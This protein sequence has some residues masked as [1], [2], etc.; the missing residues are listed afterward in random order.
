MAEAQYELQDTNTPVVYTPP[1]V[2]H[3]TVGEAWTPES[4]AAK[5]TGK[6][7]DQKHP[8]ATTDYDG[9]VRLTRRTVAEFVRYYSRAAHGDYIIYRPIDPAEAAIV[10]DVAIKAC[11][12]PNIGYSQSYSSSDSATNRT[13]I[14]RYGVDTTV[15]INCDCSS[16]GSYCAYVATGINFGAKDSRSIGSAL[17]KTGHFM[18]GISMYNVSADNLPYNGD[19]IAKDGHVAMI[20]AGHPREGMPDETIV[21]TWTGGNLNMPS[22]VLY[23]DEDGTLSFNISQYVDQFGNQYRFASRK[24]A[25][26]ETSVFYSQNY[27]VNPNGSYAWGRFSEIM[28]SVCSLYQQEARK[29]YLYKEDGYRREIAPALGAVMC[30]TNAYDS[31]DPGWVCIVEKIDTNSG[32]IWVSQ[33]DP[34]TGAFSYVEKTKDNRNWNMDLNGDG[35]YEYVFQGFIH[36]P[37]VSLITESQSALDT[38]VEIAKEQI[39]TNGDFTEQY[40]GLKTANSA[41][42][43]AF[44]LAVAHKTGGLVNVIIP[45]TTSC[46]DIGRVGYLRGM[47]KWYDGPQS[48]KFP[49]PKPGDIAL[50]RNST[51]PDRMNRYA[52]DK[53]GIIVEVGGASGTAAG[54]NQGTNYSFTVVM[55]DMSGKVKSKKYSTSS[56]SFSGIYRPDW[57]SVDGTTESLNKF[58]TIE[59]LYTEGTALED[60]AVR[61]LRY[62]KLT[63]KGFEPSIKSSGMKLCAINYTGMLANLYTAFAEVASSAATDAN[64]VVDLWNNSV[65]SVYQDD[66]ISTISLVSDSVGNTIDPSIAIQGSESGVASMGSNELASQPGGSVAT[67]SDAQVMNLPQE[68]IANNSVVSI[69]GTGLS[70]TA[71]ASRI[72]QVNTVNVTFNQKIV[73]TTA[74]KNIYNWLNAELNNPAAC[75]GIM[76]NM[77]HISAFDPNSTDDRTKGAGLIHWANPSD[78]KLRQRCT[79]MKQF[80]AQRTTSGKWKNNPQGQI[81]FIF[82]EATTNSTLNIGWSSIKKVGRDIGGAFRA[83]R[84]FLDYFVLEAGPMKTANTNTKQ[85]KNPSTNYQPATRS[86][87]DLLTTEVATYEV[88]SGW[89]S[90][91]WNLFFGGQKVL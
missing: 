51:F 68:W 24:T 12:N 1:V 67:Q 75:I 63:K 2:T 41:W 82:K 31:T 5:N 21:G 89:A 43:A 6:K 45:N 15:P 59:G 50:F 28:Q 11:N 8:D 18:K 4:G 83:T 44:I 25:P 53:A 40:T 32:T 78:K 30:Y 3:I 46:S 23:A 73:L 69:T 20:V 27:G 7:G 91:L 13:G 79:E 36:N 29:W 65:K 42:S 10:A 88:M 86:E 49:E 71:T 19:I 26:S 70:G 56:N 39:N 72:D 47:G 87:Q 90:A 16:L 55:G 62:V 74:I 52:A 38:F 54:T 85:G 61:D 48:S 81:Q 64:L 80:C 34:K 76:A 9:E 14:F 22:S 66:K 57:E 35:K 60:A 77:Y 17:V 37:A 33:R 58:N 84:L